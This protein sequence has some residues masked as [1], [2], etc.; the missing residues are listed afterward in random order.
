VADIFVINKTE[1]KNELCEA[2]TKSGFNMYH[3]AEKYL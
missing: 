3:F 1:L 2:A